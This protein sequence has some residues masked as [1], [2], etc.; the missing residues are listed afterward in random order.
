[1]DSPWNTNNS[2]YLTQ[3]AEEVDMTLNIMEMGE[4]PISISN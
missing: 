4:I 3:T 2:F 1:M